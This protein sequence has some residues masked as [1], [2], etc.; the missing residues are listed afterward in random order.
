M[1]SSQ[2][3]GD[4]PT[5]DDGTAVNF[6][7]L[8][9][10]EDIQQRLGLVILRDAA[11]D[12][13]SGILTAT[14]LDVNGPQTRIRLEVHADDRAR[15]AGAAGSECVKAD[16]R[17][18]EDTQRN[19]SLVLRECQGGTAWTHG[20]ML[21]LQTPVFAIEK[22]AT[23]SRL[24]EL[25]KQC[26]AIAHEVR[27]P[28]FTIAM[29]NE[30]L[31]LIL[32][33]Q[34][35]LP[36]QAAVALDHIQQET[37]RARAIIDQTLDYGAGRSGKGPP[38]PTDGEHA[39]P[40]ADLAHAAE[41]ATCLLTYQMEQA[42]IDL[43]TGNMAEAPPIAMPQIELEQILLNVLRNAIESIGTRKKAG[44]SGKGAI[45]LALDSGEKRL[46]CTISDNGAGLGGAEP[47]SG[48]QPFATTKGDEGNGLGLYICEQ[49][50]ARA[51]GGLRLL[52]GDREG[53]KVEITLP[54]GGE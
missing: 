26:A 18:I 32:K 30:N 33:A 1:H 6:L 13:A 42:E 4:V 19:V 10:A 20:A 36:P 37:E 16:L 29:A 31:R 22:L 49:L 54:L 9:L 52:P 43:D 12:P 51:G 34:P 47:E 28:L 11:F 3:L 38:A 39:T 41:H 48:F 44:W 14:R 23:R 7:P 8:P 46:C 21:D 17:I 27:Q 50:L 15:L 40:Q 2:I 25:G 5:P 53:A 35:D 24:A 45:R